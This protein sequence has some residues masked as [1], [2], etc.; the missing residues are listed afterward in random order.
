M[1]QGMD[2]IEG[3][4]IQNIER[5]M[6]IEEEGLFG[7]LIGS[8]NL[9]TP[10]ESGGTIQN[11][12]RVPAL[13]EVCRGKV[14]K[15]NRCLFS[16]IEFLENEETLLLRAKRSGLNWNIL[17]KTKEKVAKLSG[18]LLG[19]NYTLKHYPSKKEVCCIKYTGLFSESGP[20]SFQVF[21][22]PLYSSYDKKLT[23]R[24]KERSGQ[25]V[26]L[27]NKQPYYNSETNSYVLNFNGRVTLPSV[28]NFQIIHPNDTS[29]ITITF[30]KTGENEYVLDYTYPWC[31]V[32]AFG[33]TLSALGIKLGCE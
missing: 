3:I 14:V 20:R 13:G 9:W 27:V 25:Y 8:D 5:E 32:D 29:Y 22:D 15:R 28:R 11:I 7:P 33:L 23:Q 18:N 31:A 2:Q 17:S 26:K 24:L 16:E 19:S 4:S 12:Y 1:V 6:C 21:I 30:G 10:A